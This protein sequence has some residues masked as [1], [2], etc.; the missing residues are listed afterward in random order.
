[1]DNA[2]YLSDT[3]D[4]IVRLTLTLLVLLL[5]PGNLLVISVYAFHLTTS[6]RMYMFNLACTDT[7]ICG[8]AVFLG[9]VSVWRAVFL[10]GVSWWRA[11]FLG[12]VSWWS[13][14][15]LGGVNWWRDVF[16]DGVSVWRV[17]ILCV[18]SV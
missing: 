17:M 4:Y 3:G 18:V 5:A 7:L 2:Q 9:G 6:T 12:V 13:A 10:G 11:V 14:V 1:M 8:I 15:F 16:L